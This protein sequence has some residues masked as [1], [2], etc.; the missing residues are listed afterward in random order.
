MFVSFTLFKLTLDERKTLTKISTRKKSHNHS[1]QG[2][3]LFA[4]PSVYCLTHD[5][6]THPNPVLPLHPNPL[7]AKVLPFEG[8]T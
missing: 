2:K 1:Q 4:K 8:G 7:M 6:C 5:L 3:R